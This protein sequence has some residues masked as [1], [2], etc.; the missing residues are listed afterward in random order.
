[1]S[2]CSRA[3]CSA[4]IGIHLPDQRRARTLVPGAGFRL[5]IVDDDPMS[6][7][8]V[9]DFGFGPR[10]V[11]RQ[12][13]RHFQSLPGGRDAQ[14]AVDGR[15]GRRDHVGQVGLAALNSTAIAVDVGRVVARPTGLRGPLG[16]KRQAPG[17][18]LARRRPGRGPRSPSR[19]GTAGC[20]RSCSYRR[21][22]PRHRVEIRRAP[23]RG[24]KGW[25]SHGSHIAARARRSGHR[26]WRRSSGPARAT[27]SP[28]RSAAT[29]R[30]RRSRRSRSPW[31]RSS[32][33]TAARRGRS[34]FQSTRLKA[35]LIDS[36]IAR[37]SRALSLASGRFLHL[38]QVAGRLVEEG[39]VVAVHAAGR[40]RIVVPMG[41]DVVEPEE[42]LAV[43]PLD[44]VGEHSLHGG[45]VLAHEGQ[46]A[47]VDQVRSRADGS[48]AGCR[49]PTR[50]PGCSRNGPGLG[51]PGG[52]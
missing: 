4:E 21:F 44:E 47:G 14:N 19:S 18:T 41:P 28:R 11:R 23:A 2:G 51:R 5:T 36:A 43:A 30:G 46:V 8:L 10:P 9:Q 6:P 34:S 48:C 15:G 49:R 40:D 50:L 38:G 3:G 25:R 1:M 39:I 33:G 7:A 29:G 31:R 12:V 32:R 52:S 26:P 45:Q 20:R 27:R 13:R 17:R 37:Y 42:P 35:D 24:P 22:L 16:E